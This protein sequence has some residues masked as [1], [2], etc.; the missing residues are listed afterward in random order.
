MDVTRQRAHDGRMNVEE[1]LRDV[2]TKVSL[3]RYLAT[4]AHTCPE[5]PDPDVLLGMATVCEEVES[6]TR[7]VVFALPP[8]VGFIELRRPR[9]K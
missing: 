7:A 8:D 3:V 4:S 6:V 5:T 1:A 9:H 2:R